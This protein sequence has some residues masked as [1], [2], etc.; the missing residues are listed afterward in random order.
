MITFRGVSKRYSKEVEA[1]KNV[2]LT[3]GKGE[4]VA[5]LGKSGSG[6]S[7]LIRCINGLV[8]PSNGDITFDNRSVTTADEKTLRTIRKDI[9]MVFQR[10]HLMPQKSVVKNVLAGRLAYHGG[11]SGLFGRF[12]DAEVDLAHQA[13]TRVGLMDKLSAKAEHLSGG[14][15]QR[16]AIARA[17]VQQP[18]LILA[19][20]PVASL[21]PKSSEEVL[22][23][24]K[25]IHRREAITVVM[26]MHNVEQ[27]LKY[28]TR[29]IGLNRGEVVYDGKAEDVD[30]SVLKIIYA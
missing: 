14:Q 17:L 21:D 30:A 3:I 23:L 18:K 11:L 25:D 22:D 29:I 26:N 19:D 12:D 5:I 13:L 16:V 10:F 9:G 24:F 4:M 1:L 7:T 27:A 8:R 6:K 2:T 28:A 20:E 15:M